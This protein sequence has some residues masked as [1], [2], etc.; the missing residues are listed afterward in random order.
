[1]KTKMKKTIL[2][3]LCIL[4]VSCFVTFTQAGTRIVVLGSSTAAGAGVTDSNRAWVNQYRTYLQ[5]LDPT[6]TVTNLAK[7]GYTTCAIMPTGTE[8][9]NTGAHILE[10]D[11]ERNITKALSL[12]PNAIIINMPTNDV[13]N[14]IP[15]ATQLEHFAT[16]IDLAKAAGV[17]VWITTSQPHNYGE[18]YNGP[19]TEDN[20]PDYYKQ[21]ARDQFKELTDSIKSIYKEFALDFYTPIATEDGYSFIRPEYD[22]GDGVHLNDE[23]HDILFNIV[24]EANIPEIAG[25]TP[26]VVSTTPIYVNFGPADA[27]LESW[28]NANAQNTGSRYDMLT[29]S[30][31]TAS[32]VSIEFTVGFT[33][34]ATNGSSS[35]VWNMNEAISTSNFSSNGADPVLTISGLNPT[36]S[37]TFQT[38]GSRSG[39]GNR[40]TTYT[41]VG[42]NSGSATINAA[43]NTSEIATVSGITPTPQGVVVLTISKSANNTSGYSYINAMRIVASEGTSQPEVPEG[44]IRVDV[45]G[46]LSSLL[47]AQTDTITTLV[48]QGTLN[49]SDIK[50]IREL[51]ALKYLDM[52]GSK[53]V[54]GG[55][56]YL[57]GMGT[58]ANVFPKEM[59][60]N[61][62]VIETV[63]LPSEAIEVAYH[64]FMGCSAL[65]KVV[66]PETV[67]TFGNDL[68]SGCSNLEEINMPAEAESMGTGM[69]WGC[70]KLTSISI[71]EGITALPGG[72]FYNCYALASVTL[73]S[74][75]V[76]IDGDW[77][78]A[79]CQSL[80]SLVLP[81]SIQSIAPAIFYNCWSLNTIE[82]HAVTPPTT[83]ANGN[84][85]TPFTGAFKPEYCTLKVPFT[86]ISAYKES[87]IYGGM[88]SIVSLAEITADGTV[89][90]PEE[91][92][93]LA[94]ARK[95]V[96]TGATPDASAIGALLASNEGVTSIDMSGVTADFEPIAT[97]N[98][99]CLVYAPAAAQ[100]EADN[101]IIDGIAR[102]IVLTDGKPFEAPSDF[103]ANAISYTRSLDENL[104]TNE[105]E[106]SGWRSIV[107]PFDVTTITAQNKAG[108]TVELS[109][110]DNDGQ[111]DTA[112][113][114]FWLR[115]LTTEG[116]TAAQELSANTPYL[117][118]FPNADDLD[119][120]TNISGEVTFKAFDAEVVATPT[121]DATAGKEYDMMPTYQPVATADGIY[122]INAA[123]S[124]FV[125]NSRDIAPFECY[126]V[127]K[128]GSGEM[129]A[130]FDLPPKVPTAIDN[131]T[132]TDSKIYAAD[133]N[134][135]VISNEPAE[136][137]VYNIAG[138][139]VLLQKVEAGKTIIN[140]MP[141][142]VY[143]VN[144]QKIIL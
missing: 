139:M 46:T 34:A 143:I 130:A 122:A 81:K 134:L 79:S 9:Y 94:S 70:A 131:E 128:P 95:I 14:G 31:G 28:N 35:S 29:D 135:V 101:V 82:C 80:A 37:Y 65:K 60:V 48:L 96:I 127:C 47:P 68:F 107:L 42:E 21:T 3:T 17:K 102:Q 39:D 69:F 63:I 86:A 67:R 97:A 5:S 8:P 125:N 66:L 58:V 103:R 77:T 136:V 1:M 7:G 91:T 115:V 72:T 73:P 118:C 50:T 54:S 98:P 75:L 83:T 44:V 116:Y 141:R 27:G 126:V 33:N 16:I 113:N 108:E 117:I 111:Y 4:L 124:S 51:P 129:P 109:A 137:A 52:E 36:A 110:Y 140:D 142:G 20:Q 84:G 105:Q 112:K 40:E 61:N 55:D 43:S 120:Y 87:S 144:G 62:K 90:T 64:A 11:E 104:T 24:K 88:N 26:T 18:E 41:Y 85:D 138:Q 121:F 100:S 32:T 106:T 15:V 114:P 74:T 71:P 133:G 12:S 132:V 89:V 56:A 19:Y 23:A 92:S 2:S 53:I 45:A 30:T 76:S 57:N 123:G 13:S 59:F 22:S 10:V 119:D 25:S 38:F 99:N 93:A 78:F 49:S 6:N